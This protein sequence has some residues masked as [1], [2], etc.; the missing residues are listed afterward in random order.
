VTV[1]S[2]STTGNFAI[3]TNTCGSSINAGA[4]CTVRVHFDPSI[5]GALTGSLAISDSAPDSPQ[6]V[7]LS[8]AGILPLGVSPATL[9]FGT[10]SV[11]GSS[12]TKTVTLTNN[13]S[14][15]VSFSFSAS[16][17]Y[18]TNSS[19]TSCGNGLAAGAKCM[20]AVTFTPT[21]S[22]AINGAVSITDSS[23]FSP[24]L[25]ALSGTGSGEGTPPL[26]FT[27]ATLSFPAQV[28]G[29]TSSARS[30]S[31]KNNSASSVTLSSIAASGDFSAAGAGAKPCSAGLNLAA[32]ASCTLGVTFAPALGASG[33]ISGAVV[34]TDNAVVSQQVLD[35]KGTAALPLTFTPATLSFAGQ[36]VATASAAQTVTLTNN[37]SS[38]LSPAISGNG[39]FAAVPGGT[40]PCG[41]SLAAH[42]QCTISVTFIPSAVG[43]RGGAIT[44]FDLANPSLQTISV[45]GI[46]Q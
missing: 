3:A 39:D 35:T 38:S 11:G 18:S 24:Q 45:S 13:E 46:G 36:T 2:V 12:T 19:G 8:G 23:G 10:V 9:S 28:L 37:S 43:T 30:L 5:P 1:N 42:A 15:T 27:P 7:A 29:T 14:A 44:V 20:I 17:N 22:G 4:S 32:G 26:T 34:I 6:T 25:I 41:A 16:G 40:T 33:A 21:A 31:V